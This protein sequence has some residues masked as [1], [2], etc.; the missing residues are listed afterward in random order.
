MVINA[1]ESSELGTLISSLSP[2]VGHSRQGRLHVLG[3]WLLLPYISRDF[4]K[5]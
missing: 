3:R 4:L 5:A 1:N 2:K